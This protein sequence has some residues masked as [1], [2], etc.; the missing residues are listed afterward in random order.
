MSAAKKIYTAILVTALFSTLSACN[1]Y[2][3][4]DRKDFESN[5]ASF[6]VKNLKISGCSLNSVRSYATASK[7]ITVSSGGYDRQD[8][9]FLWEHQ[10]N[11]QSVFE[12]DNLKG[13]YCLYDNT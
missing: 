10:I 3:S 12:T 5:S 4:E 11:N 13:T 1:L 9:V 6:H 2:R 8:S 7:L